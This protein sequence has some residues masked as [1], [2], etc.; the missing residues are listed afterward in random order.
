MR[1]FILG[2]V[3]G[4]HKALIQCLERSGFDKDTDTLV[5]L[6][7]IV[8]GWS[9]VYECVETLLGIKNRIDIKGNHDEWAQIMFKTGTHPGLHHG[10]KS[11]LE[12]YIKYCGEPKRVDGEIEWN[13]TQSHI[14]FFNNQKMYHVDSEKNI[15]VHGGFNRH[16]TLEENFKAMEDIFC[17][18]RDLFLQALSSKSASSPTLKLKVKEP[19]NNIYIGHTPTLN[20]SVNQP[21]F[22]P[23]V[24][25]IDTGAGFRG[26][27]LTIMNLE[28]HEYFQSDDVETLYPNEKGRR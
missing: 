22:A 14:D 28:T 3:H 20:W 13:I 1:T 23:P 26:G 19:H 21:I 16:Y 25:N 8:D 11:T 24:I 15:F 18:D 4:A 2:D 5:S 7:D 12:S 10:G 6:G 9:E 27:R 17:W